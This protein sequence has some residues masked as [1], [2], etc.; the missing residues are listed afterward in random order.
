VP[1][2]IGEIKES[3]ADIT[4]AKEI[5]RWDPKMELKNWIKEMKLC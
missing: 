3:L 5:L 1:E 2:R 4:K